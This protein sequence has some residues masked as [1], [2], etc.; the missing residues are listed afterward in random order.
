MFFLCLLGSGLEQ[1]DGIDDGCIGMDF[2]LWF[3]GPCPVENLLVFPLLTF[4]GK[5]GNFHLPEGSNTQK[6]TSRSCWGLL[7][8]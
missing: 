8:R 3:L 7:Q 6:L 4:S 1:E 5:R 2:M